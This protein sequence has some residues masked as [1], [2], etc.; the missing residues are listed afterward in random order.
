MNAEIG[1]K[2]GAYRRK[3]NLTI[4]QMAEE[5]GLSSAIWSQLERGMGYPT[6]YALKTLANTLTIPLSQLVEEPIPNKDLI[7]RK[8]DR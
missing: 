6:L 1:R 8:K 4:R 7:L 3:H 5:T 2:I